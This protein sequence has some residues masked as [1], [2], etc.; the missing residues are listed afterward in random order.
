LVF[1]LTD[2][3]ASWLVLGL[4]LGLVLGLFFGLKRFDTH[5]YPVEA[6]RFSTK[7][8]VGGRSS[9]QATGCVASVV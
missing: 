6:L 2:G 3:L 8:H 9:G 7:G 4:P 5:P 1:A